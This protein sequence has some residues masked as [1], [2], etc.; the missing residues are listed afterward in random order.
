VIGPRVFLC[1]PRFHRL[2]GD[3]AYLEF[4]EPLG[5]AG[6][7]VS[8]QQLA[9]A[10]PLSRFQ[11]IPVVG[12]LC[13]VSRVELPA[14]LAATLGVDPPVRHSGDV[15]G[16]PRITLIGPRGHEELDFGVISLTRRLE[17]SPENARRLGL[18]DG[19]V[20]MAALRGK[21]H[22]DRR[23]ATRDGVLAD[24]HVRISDEYDLELHIDQDDANAFR[25]TSGDQAI[26]LLPEKSEEERSRG[27]L[28][29][30]RLVGE[31]DVRAAR[32]QGLRIRVTKG[33][34]LTPVARD[35][36]REWN[37]FDEA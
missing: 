1:K 28:P 18:M 3:T 19:D 37:L 12:P 13:D 14:S 6:G 35:L 27:W 16:A 36:G 17:A 33:M 29:V 23:E 9:V 8:R 30:G 34:I 25:V 22:T 10:S 2:F 32:E 21:R 20:V 11:G 15:E 5:L 31:K 7:F 26:L 24:V 4:A